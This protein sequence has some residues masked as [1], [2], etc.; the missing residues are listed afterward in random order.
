MTAF[1]PIQAIE[2]LYFPAKAASSAY[3][4]SGKLMDIRCLVVGMGISQKSAAPCSIVLHRE[5]PCQWGSGLRGPVWRRRCRSGYFKGP[6]AGF[7][8]ASQGHRFPVG[9]E[10]FTAHPEILNAV[11]ALILQAG[12]HDLEL[13]RD[14]FERV[15]P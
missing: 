12:N 1:R 11:N 6:G 7:P 4:L 5:N 14:L 15:P 9:V 8:S 13:L 10:G 3:S 2:M